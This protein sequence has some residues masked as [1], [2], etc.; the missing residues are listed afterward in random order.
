V[1]EILHFNLFR[2]YFEA[3]VAGRKRLEYRQRTPFWRKRLEG[4]KYD[5]IKLRNGYASKAPEIRRYGT[6]H[7]GSYAIS[8]GRVISLTRWRRKTAKGRGRTS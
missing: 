7:G 6:G 1:P 2:E 4:G 3:T 8:L 5:A